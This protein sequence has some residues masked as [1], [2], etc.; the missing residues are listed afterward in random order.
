[1]FD[2]FE[3]LPDATAE[4]GRLA[5]EW[6][7]KKD[8]PMY[9]DNCRVQVEAVLAMMKQEK[10]EETSYRIF[11]GWF[12]QTLGPAVEQLHQRGS[13]LALLRL[14]GDWYESTK[15]CLNWLFPQ[16]RQGAPCIVDDYYAWDGCALALH[17]YFGQHRIA[18][19]LRAMPD[20]QGVFF[21]NKVREDIREL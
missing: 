21:F 18:A 7:K 15:D 8:N 17:E 10:I 14:D 12:N 5:A 13:R 3:G 4:D 20:L 9:F 6:Q 19:R 11:K 2:S 1:M 16:L